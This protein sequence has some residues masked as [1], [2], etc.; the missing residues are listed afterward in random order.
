[1]KNLLLL[2]F[3]LAFVACKKDEDKPKTWADVKSISIDYFRSSFVFLPDDVD[4][5]VTFVSPAKE[6]SVTY[7]SP[8]NVEELHLFNTPITLLKEDFFYLK[9][10]QSDC[11]NV[12]PCPAT[13]S[14]IQAPDSFG[15]LLEREWRIGMLDNS[16]AFIGVTYN[17]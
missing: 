6:D 11:T 15:E 5:T 3:L 8:R 1:M 9:A 17:Y 16:V 2:L 7:L 4:L 12:F 13:I 10:V 14:E